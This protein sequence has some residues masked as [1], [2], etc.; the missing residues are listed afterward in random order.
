MNNMINWKRL[1]RNTAAAMAM[2]MVVSAA[3]AGDKIVAYANQEGTVTASALNVRSGPSTNNSK[4]TTINKGTKV[5]IV[6]TENG[7]HKI[8][9]NGTT[10]YVSAQ[11]VSLGDSE[12]SVTTAVGNTGKVNVSSLNVR[13]GASTSTKSIGI[14]SQGTTVSIL[15]SENGWYKVTVGLNGKDTTGYVFAEYI[16][17]TASGNAAQTA[18][19]NISSGKGKCDVSALNIRSSASTSASVV[20]V[21]SKGAEVKIFNSTGEWYQ[22]T[23]TVNGSGISGYVFAQYIAV[24]EAGSASGQASESG[25]DSIFKEVNETVWAISGVNIRKGPGTNY[26][27]IVAL[28]KNTSVI[29]TGIQSGEDGW[30][31][32]QYGNATAYV[33]SEFL[34]TKNPVQTSTGDTAADAVVAFALQFEGNPYVWAGN[35]LNTGVDCSGFTQQVYLHFGINI[36]RTADDQR[37]N[38]IVISSLDEAQPGDLIFYGSSSYADHVALY[39]GNGKI[40]HASTPKTGIIIADVDYKTP[41]QIN[42]IIY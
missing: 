28:T 38:G 16:T 15:G 31:R 22:I 11:Y 10:G 3:F 34:T 36:Y 8:S 20:G 6:S 1:I 29:R 12:S 25:T 2:V 4:I 21:L 19:Q 14:I 41:I 37:K 33:K 17:A 32:I 39:I 5:D 18:S 35:D 9:I 30:S 40:I 23:A 26:D 42:R 13:E 27:A 7:W 24:T